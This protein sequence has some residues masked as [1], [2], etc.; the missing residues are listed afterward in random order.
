MIKFSEIFL[1][2]RSGGLYECSSLSSLPDISKWNASNIDNMNHMF[3]KCS[4]ILFLLDKSKWNT[5]NVLHKSYILFKCH[6]YN[7]YLIYRNRIFLDYI[8][9]ECLS[10]SFLPDIS[11]WRSSKINDIDIIFVFY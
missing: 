10:L 11:N 6:H 5:F 1:V 7:C 9:S 3:N 2:W 8:F 4:S